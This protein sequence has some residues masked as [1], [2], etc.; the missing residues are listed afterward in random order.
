MLFSTFPRGWPGLGLLLLRAV[1]GGVVV[2][3]GAR[4]IS[5]GSSSISALLTA[6]LAIGA[7]GAVAAGFSTALASTLL[8]LGTIGVA[9]KWI[10]GS[11]R[12][13]ITPG[14]ST[15]FAVS[16]CIAIAL[17]GPGALSI[18][19]RRRGRR[20]IVIPRSRPNPST[21]RKS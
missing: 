9:F 11:D 14:V 18:D 10:P 19:A 16:M 7:G 3:H 21:R 8:S 2:A 5:A 13:G 17:L 1:I 6:A 15:I 20:E 4:A 12:N